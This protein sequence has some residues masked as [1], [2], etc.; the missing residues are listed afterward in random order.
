MCNWNQL[1]YDDFDWTR[2]VGSTP[3]QFSGPTRD[4]STGTSTGHYLYAEM[5]KPRKRGDKAQIGECPVHPFSL[6]KHDVLTTQ[7]LFSFILIPSN[8]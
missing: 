2:H 6:D 5:S 4:H 8:A 1:Q 3:T 7:K